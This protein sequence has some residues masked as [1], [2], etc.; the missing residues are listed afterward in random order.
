[1][2]PHIEITRLSGC[3]DGL[4]SLESTVGR[5]DSPNA[6]PKSEQINAIEDFASSWKWPSFFSTSVFLWAISAFVSSRFVFVL[7]S[8]YRIRQFVDIFLRCRAARGPGFEKGCGRFRRARLPPTTDHN[9]GDLS[10]TVQ[11]IFRKGQT[12][13]AGDIEIFFLQEEVKKIEFRSL[14]RSKILEPAYSS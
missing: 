11:Q 1:M 2:S 13:W 5:R 9:Q 6:P 14:G 12:T 10:F 8:S 3:R 4:T 7:N